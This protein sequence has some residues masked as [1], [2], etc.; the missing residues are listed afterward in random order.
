[1][2]S[3]IKWIWMLLLAATFA[4]CK[5]TDYFIGGSTHNPKFNGTTYEYLKTNPLFDTLVLLIDKTGLKDEVNAAGTFF[6]P[7]DYA[8]QNY[9][10]KV[11]QVRKQLEANDENLKFEFGEL[12]FPKYK[13]SLRAYLF[14]QRIERAALTKEG[15]Y[16]TSKDG[17]KRHITLWDDPSGAYINDGLTLIP[18]Y[19][20]F[21]KVIGTLDPLINDDVP[22]EERDK[23]VVVQTSGVITNNGVVHVLANYHNFTFVELN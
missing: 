2:Q 14:P 10:K 3:N 8:I 15:Q 12:D 19:I 20:Y 7:T 16:Y 13:D 22:T 4:S 5:K 23:R 1:M 17:E 18:K 6:A 9:V 11:V 21:T